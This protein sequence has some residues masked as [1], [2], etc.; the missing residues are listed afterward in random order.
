MGKRKK[1]KYEHIIVTDQGETVV[2]KVPASY[3]KKVHKC[4][5]CD[6]ETEFYEEHLLFLPVMFTGNRRYGHEECYEA[7]KKYMPGG[8]ISLHPGARNLTPGL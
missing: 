4:L 3:A 1:D 6:E 8:M 2:K 7:F 5:F